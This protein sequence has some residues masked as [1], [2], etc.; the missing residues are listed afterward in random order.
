MKRRFDEGDDY[1]DALT[2]QWL[3]GTR[4]VFH[5]LPVLDW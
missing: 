4:Q 1:F 2:Q 3:A 5:D